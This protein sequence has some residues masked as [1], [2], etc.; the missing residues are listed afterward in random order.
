MNKKGLGKGLGALIPGNKTVEKTAEKT[1]EDSQDRILKLPLNKII[2][3]SSQP[4][5]DFNQEKIEELAQSIKENGLI[6]PIVVRKKM[7]KYQ[8]VA[9]E[10]R[11]RACAFL[12]LKEI[13]VIL[14]EFS[15]GDTSK[16]ALIENIQRQDLNPVEEALAYKGLIEEHGLKQSELGEILGKSRSAITNALRLLELPN[17]VLEMIRK[18]T[19]SMGHGRALLSLESPKKIKECATEVVDREL[20]VR[21]TEAL[22][23]KTLENKQVEQILRVEN[24]EL[25]RIK[26]NLQEH[27]STKVAIKG[28]EQKGKIE[29]DYYSLEDLN[30]ILEVINEK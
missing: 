24:V 7:N 4:R 3:N 30:R 14:K 29:I 20:S 19:I 10:R 5:K 11:F 1:T 25:K 18:G 13:S 6:Q 26:E 12:K 22:V 8:I 27:F 9:G 2:S 21:Q 23:K 17:E 15:D 16:I 28:T